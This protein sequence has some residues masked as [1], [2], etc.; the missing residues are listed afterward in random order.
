VVVVVDTIHDALVVP[1]P[2]PGLPSILVSPRGASGDTA[3]IRK[4]QGPSTGLAVPVD[5]AVDPTR[6]E[7]SC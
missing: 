2:G 7:I 6:N 3:P 4:I 1:N 5:V